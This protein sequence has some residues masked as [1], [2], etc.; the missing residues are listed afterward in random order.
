[1]MQN[2]MRVS[3]GLDE[4]KKAPNMSGPYLLLQGHTRPTRQRPFC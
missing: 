4:N 3:D 1:M 2:K